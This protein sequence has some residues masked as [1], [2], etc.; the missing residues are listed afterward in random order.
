MLRPEDT[1]YEQACV[2]TNKL[3]RV[4]DCSA[5]LLSDNETWLQTEILTVGTKKKKK[6]DL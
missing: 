1:F 4:I 2:P 3:H 5:K 6:K